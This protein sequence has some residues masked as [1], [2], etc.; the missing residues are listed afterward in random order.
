MP[1]P[2][3]HKILFFDIESAGVNALHSDL[4]FCIIF[5]YKWAHEKEVHAL[6]VDRASLRKFSDKKLLQQASAIFSEADLVVA[7][8]GSVFDRRFI[9]GRLLVNGLPPIPQTKMRDTCFIARSVANFSSNRL[10]HLAKL[11]GFRNQKLENNWPVA[12]FQVMQG[13]MKALAGLA[14]YC[15]GDILAL[16]ELY[17]KLLPFDNAHPR[18]VDNRSGCPVC[19]GA[20]QYR[21]FSLALNRKYRRFQCLKCSRWGRDTQAVNRERKGA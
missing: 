8:F 20:V 6:T 9:Q 4:G 11:L 21:G 19:G 17:Y 7:H 1:V 2:N 12:W 5:G 14:H 15:K 16:E 13:N 18:V 3:T 10:K